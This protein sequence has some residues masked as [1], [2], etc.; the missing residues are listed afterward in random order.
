MPI[1]SWKFHAGRLLLAAAL[2][3]LA[4]WITGHVVVVVLAALLAHVAWH[5]GNLW[6]LYR[7]LR[8]PSAAIPES[9]GIWADIYERIDALDRESNRQRRRYREVIGEFRSLTDAF[10]DAT[11][12][13]DE[14]GV[15]TWFNTGATRLLGLKDP[16]DL[17]KP[18]TNLLRSTDFANWLTVQEEVTSP[19]EMPSPRGDDVW[20]SVLAV[21]FRGQQ[22]LIIC[23][24]VTEVHNVEKIRR[25]FVA[26]ISHELRT[27]LT[28]LQGYL[29]LLENHASSEVSEA[30]SRMLAQTLQMQTLLNDLLELSRLQS[31]ESNA[32]EEVVN[33]PAMLAQLKEQAQEFSRGEHDLVFKVDESLSLSGVAADIESA[34]SNLLSNAV[35]YTPEGGTITVR[36]KDREKGPEFSVRDT[37]IGIPRREI[38][39]LTERFYR[40]GSD[41]A[42][43]TG[44]TGLGLAIVKHVL[45]THQAELQIDSELGEGSTFVCTFPP[46]RRRENDTEL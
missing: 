37:G 33:V 31:E 22:R 36:W 7:W 21:T 28:V 41:R 16:E 17:G 45:N 25:D 19:L 46:E 29:E 20:L 6:R 8:T 10:P 14:K 39:R 18:V 13:L 27:P 9:Y 3:V 5:L 34:F 30:V 43:Q 23:R 1:R 38:P 11:L 26:N 12:V 40:V 2:V 44:G 32:R 35:K 24:D 4:G 15:L 42:R